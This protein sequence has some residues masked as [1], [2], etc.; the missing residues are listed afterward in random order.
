M[1][2]AAEDLR[3]ALSRSD[4]FSIEIDGRA[5]GGFTRC[6]GLARETSVIELH[7]GGFDGVRCFRDAASPVRLVLER[8][9]GDREL[10][11][12][13]QRGDART[14]AILLLDPSG[15][16]RTRWTFTGAWPC[17]WSGPDLDSARAHVALERVEIIC[18]ELRWPS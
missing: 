8:G 12:W 13:Y 1:T 6:D 2:I 15:A 7:E 5:L 3:A 4:C 10:W 11:D 18:E 9:L 16:E 14:G 17:A